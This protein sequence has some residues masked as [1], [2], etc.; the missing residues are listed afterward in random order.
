MNRSSPITRL[1]E[2]VLAERRSRDKM[3]MALLCRLKE[4][5]YA[6]NLELEQEI[7]LER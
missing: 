6:Q 1:L 3:G 2:D 5:L 4:V 7:K